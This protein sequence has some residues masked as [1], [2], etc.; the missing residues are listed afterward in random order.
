LIPRR[1]RINK[2][3]L[4]ELNN[5][6]HPRFHLCINLKPNQ[7]PTSKVEQKN[8]VNNRLLIV[9]DESDALSH[10][11]GF[12]ANGFEVDAFH[13]PSLAL[14][15]FK[16]GIYGLLLAVKMPQING[17]ELYEKIK[18]IDSEVRACFNTVQEV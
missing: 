16:P 15:N 3:T 18:K 12:E 9:D 13:D 1:G 6:D 5:I 14:S 10:K 2:A 17:F 11:R 7:E 8:S 4:R